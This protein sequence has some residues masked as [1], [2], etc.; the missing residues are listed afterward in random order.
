MKRAIKFLFCF[1]FLCF[2]GISFFRGEFFEGKLSNKLASSI[3]A[4]GYVL[5]KN[6]ENS[7]K[8]DVDNDNN[9]FK[10]NIS[11][12]NSFNQQQVKTNDELLKYIVNKLKITYVEDIDE[13][14][15][16]ESAIKGMLSSLDPHSRY[17]NKKEYKEME[18]NLKGEFGGLG[19]VVTKNTELFITVISPL[20]DTP[21]YK[22]GIKSGDYI[23]QINDK[24][25]FDMDLYQAIN[26]MRGKVGEKVKLTILRKGETKP[27]EFTLRREKIK[28]NPVKG[29]IVNGNIAYIRVTEFKDHLQQDIINFF[30]KIKQD[31]KGN[32]LK[33]LILDLRNNPG[34]LLTEAIKVS[35][36]FLDKD[37]VVVSTKDKNAKS[38]NLYKTTR[39]NVLIN[40]NTP[41]VV[42]VN[43]G[44][45]SASEIV[46]GAIQ[47]H[48]RGLV[49]GTKTFGKASVQTVYP[50]LNGG[51]MLITTARYYTPSNRSIQL[52]G[53]K[54][55]IIVKQGKITFE[56]N[57]YDN[58]GEKDLKGHLKRED[59]DIVQKT[60][61]ENTK[62]KVNENYSDDYQLSRA[63]DLIKELN[64]MKSISSEKSTRN[65]V[66]TKQ[67]ISNSANNNQNK[68][69]NDKILDDKNNKK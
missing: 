34:G 41:L 20:E 44:S 24:S 27:L 55:D 64:F 6:Q 32:E 46:S 37:K 56:D 28:T 3:D 47:D 68:K 61:R 14:K 49:L 51:A 13:E 42:L 38:L 4:E 17:L 2:I 52:E 5:A 39:G 58:F 33:G 45:A 22:A 1:I 23:S 11:L 50:L 8:N 9:R 63:V 12:F 54:P 36:L 29:K 62:E 43:N 59:E 65:K 35:E 7:I 18:E 21:A 25:T 10:F 57:I 67:N 15:I 19:I 60:I 30:N 53:I 69:I 48:K 31:L 26:I 16:Y 66:E 40:K